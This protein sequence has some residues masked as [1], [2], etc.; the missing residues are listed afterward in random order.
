MFRDLVTFFH[1]TRPRSRE[2]LGE[3][4]ARSH[5]EIVVSA[6]SGASF[7]DLLLELFRVGAFLGDSLEHLEVVD[8]G[9]DISSGLGSVVGREEDF[10]PSVEIV[11]QICYDGV[12]MSGSC[13]DGV[14]V[15]T[16]HVHVHSL[17][18]GNLDFVG[19]VVGVDHHVDSR[20]FKLSGSDPVSVGGDRVVES[21]SED[22]GEVVDKS[23]SSSDGVVLVCTLG[24]V[25]LDFGK[26]V[27][28]SVVGDKLSLYID[29]V[30][31]D[32]LGHLSDAVL[33]AGQFDDDCLS[34][35]SD[36]VGL[37]EHDDLILNGIVRVVDVD[38]DLL[39]V[40]DSHFAVLECDLFR[41]HFRFLL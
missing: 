41:V 19:I 4:E 33:E 16:E 5:S 40:H 2:S 3:E 7:V 23:L 37:L 8:L 36:E 32:V 12:G 13:N 21:I 18:L 27:S 39:E 9:L 28:G 22:S 1:V 34:A 26:E 31:L 11:L 38:A 15:V 24:H 14:A 35:L 6:V 17:R 20:D 10:E 29:L 25:R 30:V